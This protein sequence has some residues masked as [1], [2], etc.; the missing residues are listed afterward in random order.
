MPKS[1][2]TDILPVSFKTNVTAV[3][4]DSSGK[5][6]YTATDLAQPVENSPNFLSALWPYPLV[7]D[8]GV[9]VTFGT[10]SGLTV[11]KGWDNVTG[12]GV[13]VPKAFAD[14]FKP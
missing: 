13:P 3:V 8:T 6:K 5:T 14:Y 9:L 1:T 2:I 10:D 7:E 12:F 11:T 4:Q